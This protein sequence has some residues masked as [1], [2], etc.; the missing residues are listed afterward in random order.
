M[1]I[2]PTNAPTTAAAAPLTRPR[3]LAI[4]SSCDETACAI[5]DGFDV[6]A[7]VVAS[8][9]EVHARFGGIVPELASRHHLSAIVPVIEEAMEQAGVAA[10]A[11]LDALAVTDGPGL[12]GALL[13]GVQAARGIAAATELPLL[14]IHHMEGHIFSA[15]LGD[16]ERAA[17]PFEPH[18]ALLVSGGHSELVDVR[19]LGEYAILGATRD[20]AARSPSRGRCSAIQRTSSSPSRASR[21]PSWSTSKSTASRPRGRTSPTSARPSRRRS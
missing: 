18:L 16:H 2:G 6:R 7:S 17:R 5:V 21:Q 20:D 1:S 13:V 14:G 11:E 4:E 12:V 3:V 15:L 10:F 19:G 9:I 8:Q